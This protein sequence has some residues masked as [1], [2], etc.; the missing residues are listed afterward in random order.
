MPG[1]ECRN[2]NSNK[3][4][5]R[6]AVDTC[7]VKNLA[8]KALLPVPTVF[9]NYV[10]R[11]RVIDGDSTTTGPRLVLTTHK[12]STFTDTTS[13]LMQSHA[14]AEQMPSIAHSVLSRRTFLQTS[15]GVTTEFGRENR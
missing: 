2:N 9:D 6:S 13:H 15:S 12:L 3:N 1:P 4:S 14:R 10:D 7:S 8:T 11:Y 5:F